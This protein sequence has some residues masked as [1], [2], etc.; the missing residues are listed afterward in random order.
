MKE[1]NT[2][3]PKPTPVKRD[4]SAFVAQYSAAVKKRKTARNKRI[5]VD[6]DQCQRD[7]HYRLSG[8]GQSG[9]QRKV[10]GKAV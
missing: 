4:H 5:K 9:T 3:D 8:F 1:P 6:A 7:A 2:P 10:R